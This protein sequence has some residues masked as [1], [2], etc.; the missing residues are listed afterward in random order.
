M[1]VTH[2]AFPYEAHGFDAYDGDHFDRHKRTAQQRRIAQCIACAA[3]GCRRDRLAGFRLVDRNKLDGTAEG[4]D[5]WSGQCKY[6]AVAEDL[7]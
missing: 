4:A 2:D 7:A 3:E 5:A 1:R 6:S